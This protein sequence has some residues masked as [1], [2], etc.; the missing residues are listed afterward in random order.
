MRTIIVINNSLMNKAKMLGKFKTKREAVEESLRLLI[1]LKQQE[2]IRK[3]RGKLKWEG[4]LDE[5]RL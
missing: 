2:K 1:R 4:S 5:M 3:Y